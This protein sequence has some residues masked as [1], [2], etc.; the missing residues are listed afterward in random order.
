MLLSLYFIIFFFF[1]SVSVLHLQELQS[2]IA[3]FASNFFSLDSESLPSI[4]FRVSCPLLSPV[5][6]RTHTIEWILNCV[7]CCDDA[8][9]VH[10]HTRAHIYIYIV[11]KLFNV[12]VVLILN[13]NKRT[14]YYRRRGS[15][16]E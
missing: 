5:F 3:T 12:V 2:L 6:N 13:N 7:V 14:K 4:Y 16:M 8:F 15:G 11:I 1:L 9:A 10:T